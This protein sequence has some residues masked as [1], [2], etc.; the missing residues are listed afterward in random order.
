MIRVLSVVR[1]IDPPTLEE[2][3]SPF[4]DEGDDFTRE[5]VRECVLM[6]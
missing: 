5:S 2:S 6:W 1:W 4:I 3:V